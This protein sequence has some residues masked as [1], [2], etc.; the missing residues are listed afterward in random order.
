MLA[1]IE[2]LEAKLSVEKDKKLIL[3]QLLE[4][5]WLVRELNPSQSAQLTTQAYQLA[6]NQEDPRLLAHAHRNRGYVYYLRSDHKN[7]LKHLNTALKL[8]STL[9]D[10]VGEGTIHQVLAFLFAES[11]DFE[12]AVNAVYK[13]Y[14][15]FDEQPDVLGSAWAEY[16]MGSVNLDLGN[17]DAAL[18]HFEQAEVRF[19]E[20]NYPLGEGRALCGVGRVYH[21]RSSYGRALDY[22]TRSLNLHTEVK[23]QQGMA[24]TS[25]FLGRQYKDLEDFDEALRLLYDA[26]QFCEQADYK[27]GET[28]ALLD[29]GEVFLQQG[30]IDESM[31]VLFKALDYARQMHAKPMMSVAHKLLAEAYAANQQYEIAY[32]HNANYFDLQEAVFSDEARARLRN[33]Q[34]RFATEKAKTEAE[35]YQL[36]NVELVMS[37]AELEKALELT[38]DSIHY[39]S[40][41]QSAMLPSLAR[42]KE[43]L[44]D[45]FIYYKP[46]DVVSGDFYWLAEKNDYIIIAAVDCTG[47]GVPGAFMSVLGQSL[48]NQ[49]VKE[50]YIFNPAQILRRLDELLVT[51]LTQTGSG[52]AIFDGME[53]AIVTINLEDQTLQYAGANIPLYVMTQSGLNTLQAT[54]TALGGTQLRNEAKEFINYTRLFAPGDTLYMF[55]D[56]FRDQFGKE[57]EAGTKLKYSTRRFQ[58]LLQELY[59][60]PLADQAIKLEEEFESWRGKLKQLDDVMVIGIRF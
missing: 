37:H 20:A 39:A 18:V 48:L 8:Y 56:G 54:H 45:A 32:E 13:S 50:N 6:L 51:M 25:R 41:I 9:R 52:N 14:A 17:Q 42:F 60:L 59:P 58:K 15:I 24:E 5:A 35:L 21:R 12:E 29:V 23:N 30:L 36:K 55:S 43:L 44:P 16:C 57:P 22:F 28:A 53:A 47:H 10:R 1:T 33:Q 31:V 49:I 4:L 46:R 27:Y 26:A 7:A 19:V 40:R 11:G 34:I 2:A 3:P 38:Q